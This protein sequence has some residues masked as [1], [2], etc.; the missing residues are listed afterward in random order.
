[1]TATLRIV[2]ADPHSV[3]PAASALLR[4]IGG[5]EPER[6][7]SDA[8]ETARRDLA[9]GIAMISLV[10]SVPGAALAALEVRDRLTR[11][12]LAARVEAAKT[13]LSASSCDAVLDLENGGSVDLVREPTDTVVDT[14][15][16]DREG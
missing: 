3:E 10:L 9:T 6:L 14:I 7:A 12:D 15:L 2:G 8:G 13:A 4:A 1:M 5:Q 11:R 16:G